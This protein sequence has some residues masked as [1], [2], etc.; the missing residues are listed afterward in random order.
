M[1]TYTFTVLVALFLGVMA[2]LAMLEGRRRTE[3]TR[4]E[5]LQR[6]ITTCLGSLQANSEA[7]LARVTEVL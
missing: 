3:L 4:F 6:T 2:V 5:Q 7:H 1:E